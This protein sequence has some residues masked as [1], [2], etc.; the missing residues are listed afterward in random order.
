MRLH[1]VANLLEN[2]QRLSALLLERRIAPPAELSDA[3]D[4]LGQ[5]KVC[6]TAGERAEEEKGFFLFLFLESVTCRAGPLTDGGAK[7][8]RHAPL[9]LAAPKRF[10]RFF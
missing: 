1:V 9:P 4:A 10:G 2:L 5:K 8:S 6:R 3:L 7:C